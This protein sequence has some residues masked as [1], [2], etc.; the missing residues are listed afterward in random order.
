MAAI[1]LAAFA[2]VLALVEQIVLQI[3]NDNVSRGSV[4]YEKGHILVLAWANT[5]RDREVIWKILAQLCLAYR[6]DGGRVIVVL[7]LVP[8]T[9]MEDTFRNII[10]EDERYG[11]TFVFRQGNPLLPDD[12]RVVA[13]SSAAATVLVS[14]TSRGPGEADSQSLRAAVLLDELDFPG[15][16]KPDP[17]RGY[18]VVGLQT[19][20]AVGL[21]KYS[22]SARVIPVP[23]N[24][25]NARRIS[26]NIQYPVLTY[27][28]QML[29]NFRSRAQGYLMSFQAVQGMHFGEL[30]RMFPDAIILGISDKVTGKTILNPPAETLLGPDDSLVLMRP[31]SIPEDDYR[32][33]R[34]PLDVDLGDW[35]SEGYVMRSRDEQPVRVRGS[36]SMDETSCSS[37]I[38]GQPLV[39]KGPRKKNG[40]AA[41]AAGCY[42]MPMEY[43]ATSEEPVN[44]LVCGWGDSTFM[45]TLL[46]SLDAELPKMSQITLLNLQRKEDVLGV[47]WEAAQMSRASVIHVYGD[48]LKYRDLESK[49]EVQRF[50]SAIVLCDAAW[51]DPDQNAANGI[52]LRTKDDMLRLD[53]MV[54]TVQLSIRKLLEERGFPDINIITEKIAFQGI[55]RFE[56]RGRMPLGSVFN[57]T[58]FSARILSQA[59]YNPKAVMAYSEF[60]KDTE[61]MVQDSSSFA[62]EGEE[63]SFLQLQ[64]RAMEVGQV[65]VGFYDIPKSVEQPLQ[66]VINPEGVDARSRKVVWNRNDNRV[67]LICLCKKSDPVDCKWPISPE[68]RATASQ[69]NGAGFEA[70]PEVAK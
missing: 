10:P 22:C 60:G 40:I 61:M 37:A 65:L 49:L 57:I 43:S 70:A 67:K 15:L 31:T 53:S 48:P 4:V 18:V 2:I 21:L 17:R 42:I 39:I 41:Q 44:V 9:E 28:S 5:Q 64:A 34:K 13:A 19:Q 58:S 59:I 55:T 23:T 69:E 51:V 45:I 32:P 52:A 11:S 12:L 26:R 7:S 62:S 66:L 38:T 27:V 1:G 54:M 16:G 56:D 3:L 46:H 33:L 35:S 24:N 6:T 36:Q 30:Y 63:V 29:L 50:N 47:A 8:K 25:L 20:E 68:T 14:D